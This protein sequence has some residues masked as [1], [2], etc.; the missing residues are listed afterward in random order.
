VSEGYANL[1]DDFN[2]TQDILRDMMAQ[3]REA[4]DGI[5]SEATKI[6]QSSE[7][8]SQRTETQAAT[9][10]QSVA[11]LEQVTSQVASSSHS[12]KVL[13]SNLS[14]AR[15]EAE[16][17]ENIV[18][19]AIQAMEDI[20]VSSDKISRIVGV[21]DNI[22]FQTNLLA[23]NAGVEAA[24]AGDAGK[25]FAVVASEVRG[26]AQRSSESAL[27]IKQLIN[28]SAE[29]VE[30]GVE[31]VGDA[32]DA[33]MSMLDRF[34][35]S[36]EMM[37]TIASSF[38]EQATRLKEINTAMSQLDRV[39]QNNAAMVTQSTLAAKKLST[40]ALMMAELSNRFVVSTVSDCLK[41]NKAA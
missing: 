4:S 22:S 1:R 12:T 24:R 7:D 6:N 33:L 19:K 18:R 34:G 5:S 37:K 40:Q 2:N 23:L 32:G 16:Q 25:G 39:T 29:Q 15:Y 17:C 9:L 36:S 30:H 35:N 11:A 27:E 26:L 10:E 8:L 13:E 21:I 31:F 41:K 14:E 20:K 38:S 3:M 28:A